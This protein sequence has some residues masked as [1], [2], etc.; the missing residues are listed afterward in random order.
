MEVINLSWEP[1]QKLRGWLPHDL[2]ASRVIFFP[3]ACPGKSPLPTGT[4]VQTA[5]PA[6]RRF[7]VSDC[8]CGMRLLRSGISRKDLSQALW[9]KLAARI[10]AN[11][12]DLGDLGGGNH[13]LDAIEPYSNDRIHFLVHT[14]SRKES[15]LVDELVSTPAAFDAEFVRVVAWARR[16]RETIQE[17]IEAVFGPAE[18]ILD[19]A[20]NNY[21]L[22]S[23]GS[24]LIRKGAV[25]LHPGEVTVVPSHMTGDVAL[26]RATPRI[27]EVLNSMSHGT[28]RA[29]PKGV[30]KAN[31]SDEA[32]DRLREEIMMPSS[33][34]T[35]SLRGEGPSS[36]RDLDACLDLLHGYV[37]VIERFAVVAYMGHL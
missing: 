29:A 31:D 23:D 1:E 13:F 8:G 35:A 26:L 25:A 33:L 7:A 22:L 14:G 30:S 11:K 36:Y 18:L 5:S 28:G 2:E 16:N 4:A 24:A 12:G 27:R 32:L 6:W 10:R 3:D 34:A 17:C 37:S 9:D 21:E 20:H 15:G 19:L